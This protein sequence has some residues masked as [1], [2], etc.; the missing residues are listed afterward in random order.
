MYWN[1]PLI[2]LQWPAARDPIVEIQHNGIHCLLWNPAAKFDNVV[3]QQ[4]LG[5]LCKWADDWL[6]LKGI[7]VF[8]SDPLNHY[9]IANLVKLNMWIKSMRTQGIVKPWLL[10]DQGN[11]TFL[12]GTGDSRLRCLERMP[13]ITTVP[14]FVSTMSNRKH[15]YPGLEEVTTFD[16]FAEL[17]GAVDGQEFLFR[18][19]DH[20]APYGLYWYEY[21]SER[22]RSVTPGEAEAVAMFSNYMQANPNTKITP[23]WFDSEIT[24][25]HHTSN[26]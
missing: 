3:T 24:W 23:E 11:G 20:E 16:R 6:Q 18:P 5:D 22:T 21:N 26:S 9:D 1:N 12:A 14:A 7:D 15:L 25:E 10:L 2:E 8:A 19:T 13:E 17:C 4:R